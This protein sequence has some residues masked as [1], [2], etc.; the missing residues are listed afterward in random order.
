MFPVSSRGD[1]ATS[2]SLLLNRQSGAALIV[3]LMVTCL[4]IMFCFA[5]LAETN[6]ETRFSSRQQ[7]KTAAF[8]LAEAG[9]QRAYMRLC[10]D[11]TWRDG[12]K[13]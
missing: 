3:S 8:Y 2:R 5:F 6:T 9:A 10:S 7:A 13:D 11:F 4:L 12:F 1:Q